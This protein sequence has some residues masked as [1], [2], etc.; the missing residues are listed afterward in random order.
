MR[1]HL[2]NE[3]I[4]SIIRG[5]FSR[6]FKSYVHNSVFIILKLYS[7]SCYIIA[8]KYNTKKLDTFKIIAMEN[9]LPKNSLKKNSFSN[10][11][12]YTH[13]HQK[14]KSNLFSNDHVST[15]MIKRFIIDCQLFN[16]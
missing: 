11:F 16:P 2:V 8:S 7:L 13:F 5:A 14:S 12:Q 10:G 4:S 3:L 15:P 1:P 6:T 9:R